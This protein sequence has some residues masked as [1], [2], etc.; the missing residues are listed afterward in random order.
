MEIVEA[1]C[2]SALAM[3]PLEASS[4]PAMAVPTPPPTFTPSDVQENMIPS[5]RL[6]LRR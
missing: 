2:T 1:G 4:Q 5:M 6:P 3:Y